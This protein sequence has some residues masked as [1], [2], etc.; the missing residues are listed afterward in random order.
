MLRVHEGADAPFPLRLGHGVERE[1][2]LAGGFGTVDLDDAA[3]RQ[4]AD[5][6][7]DVEAEQAVEIVSISN[8]FWLLPSRMMEPL[9]KA[10]SIWESAASRARL[11]FIH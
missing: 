4:T 2:R 1:R 3:A 11:V 7:R 9:P 6:E 5:A 8:G 10:R